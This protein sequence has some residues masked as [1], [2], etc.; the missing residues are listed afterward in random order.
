MRSK[1]FVD[2]NLWVY[3]YSDNPKGKIVKDL[4]DLY[5]CNIVIS[6]QVLGEFF[7]VLVRKIGK[8]KEEAKEMVINLLETFE[9]VKINESSV[10]KA[11]EISIRYNFSYWDSLIVAS[12]LENNCS[13]LYTEDMQDGQ[14]IEESLKIVNPFSK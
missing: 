1:V 14:V 12:A 2:T 13:I 3:L 7:N 6:V 5:F 4:I 8:Q 9:V 11:M 10:L